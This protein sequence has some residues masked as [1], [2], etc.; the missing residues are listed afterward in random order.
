VSDERYPD[1]EDRYHDDLGEHHWR[2]RTVIQSG[3]L[4]RG[5]GRS[6]LRRV[7]GGGG[8]FD[9][10]SFLAAKGCVEPVAKPAASSTMEGSYGH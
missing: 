1:G 4:T 7:I 9:A 2:Q 5:T 3:V 6:T 10:R 8:A